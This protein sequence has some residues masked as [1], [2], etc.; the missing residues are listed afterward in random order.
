[1]HT[2]CSQAAYTHMQHSLFSTLQQRGN[3]IRVHSHSYQLPF[4]LHTSEYIP[5]LLSY[6]LII[7]SRVHGS[8]PKPPPAPW[9]LGKPSRSTRRWPR[10]RRSRLTRKEA[11]ATSIDQ[12]RR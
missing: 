4:H 9:L 11:V 8:T 6:H 5:I 10:A 3:K 1:M 7:N 2:G 12:V